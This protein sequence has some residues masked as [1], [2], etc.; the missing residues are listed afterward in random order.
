M[1]ATT[2]QELPIERVQ[3]NPDQPRKHFSETKLRELADSIKA[4][5]LMQ[6]IRVRPVG[7]TYQIV[8][9]E[10]RWRACGLAGLK[11]IPAIVGEL[12]DEATALL[13]I[14]ENLHRE[15]INPMEESNAYAKLLEGFGDPEA[16]AKAVGKPVGYVRDRLAFQSLDPALQSVLTVNGLSLPQALH[17]AQLGSHELQRAAFEKLGKV[18]ARQG[19]WD[20]MVTAM[21]EAEKQGG[22][23]GPPPPPDPRRKEVLAKY[24]RMLE[25]VERLVRE[26]FKADELDV[27]AKALDGQTAARVERIKLIGRHLDR[28]AEALKQAWGAQHALDL[29]ERK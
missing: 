28:I 13:A 20:R 22:L 2:V 14:M 16:V 15:D 18:G 11:T 7:G 17:L 26:S 23:F 29:M 10:R 19:D 4:Q 25:R 6:P 24:D 1:M 12:S 9:G 3:P 5:G 21:A 27:L 8:A